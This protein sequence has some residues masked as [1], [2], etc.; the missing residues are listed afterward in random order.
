MSERRNKKY[1]FSVEGETEELYFKHLQ[2]LIR[3]EE[4]RIANPVFQIEK[5]SPSKCVK[6]ISVLHSCT[7]TAVFD[8]EDPDDD[9]RQR[10]ENT[11]K[12]MKAS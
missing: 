11:L 3:A 4:N 8:V 7:I 1:L 2:N 5:C 12:E 6:K 10:F 9:H